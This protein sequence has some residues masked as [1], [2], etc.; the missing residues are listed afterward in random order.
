MKKGGR[1]E[2]ETIINNYNHMKIWLDYCTDVGLTYDQATFDIHL[3]VFRE[4]LLDRGVLPQSVNVYYRTWRSFYEW[5]DSQGLLHL[6]QFPA[7]LPKKI[8]SSGGSFFQSNTTTIESDPAL[9]AVDVSL[10]YK[11]F[12]LNDQ[13]YDALAEALKSI[14]PVYEMIAYIMVTTGLRIGGVLQFPVGAT[15]RNPHW[16]RYPELAATGRVAQKLIYLPKGKK[17]FRSC[18]VV[19]EA[20]AKVH[21]EYIQN[22]RLERAEMFSGRSGPKVIAPMWLNKHGKTVFDYDVWNA[23]RDASLKIGRRVAPHYLRHT[24]A[25]YI[26]YNYFRAHGL[27]PNLAYAHDIHE[28]LKAQLGHSDIEVT[29]GYIRTIIRVE[30][31][32]WLPLL[33]P[34]MKQSVNR[35][36]PRIVLESVVSF[37]ENQIG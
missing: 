26:V 28:Q 4:Y 1:R 9:L 37:F 29:K 20:L 7:K 34:K 18:I 35:D 32:A 8:K 12:V 33:T 30:M 15:E 2:A 31:E 16:L 19:T 13:E 27:K 36:M 25:T 10:D 23:F 22:L 3:T 24:Y 14:D 17:R 5:C 11:E 6:M 21:A